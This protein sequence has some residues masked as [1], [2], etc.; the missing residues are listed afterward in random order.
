MTP[1]ML[2]VSDVLDLPTDVDLP[3]IQ[4]SRRL[5]AAIGADGHVECRCL[6]EQL[7]CEANVVLTAND[8]ERIELTDDVRVGQLSFS[9]S[10]ADRQARIVTNIGHEVAVGHLYG[11]GSR[12]LGNVELTGADQVEKLIL[13]LVG[14]SRDA[15]GDEAVPEPGTLAL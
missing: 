12:H 15:R 9:M 10:Y 14:G 5:P 7:V 6:A 2:R 8:R 1:F 4:A 3:D 11:I 13:L